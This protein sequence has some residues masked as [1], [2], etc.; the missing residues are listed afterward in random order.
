M[1]MSTIQ[2]KKAV[3]ALQTRYLIKFAVIAVLFALFY[4]L[5]LMGK[6]DYFHAWLMRGIVLVFIL[7][8]IYVFITYLRE[9]ATLANGT[10]TRRR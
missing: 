9:K 2:N 3:D 10:T 4:I 6:I 8:V 5:Y 7:G 1:S